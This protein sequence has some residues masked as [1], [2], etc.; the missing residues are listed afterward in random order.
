MKA[1]VKAT[2]PA[3][4]N[5]RRRSRDR[6]MS[7][8]PD[9][10]RGRSCVESYRS[11]GS[12]DS[13]RSIVQQR[14][15]APVRVRHH[16]GAPEKR[17]AALV[18]VRLAAGPLMRRSPSRRRIC[19]YPRVPQEQTFRA[20]VRSTNATFERGVELIGAAAH[21]YFAPRRARKEGVG[22]E[23]NTAEQFFPLAMQ[24]RA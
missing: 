22:A 8:T 9:S 1:N 4:L 12:F 15:G 24:S 14:S 3:L 17:Q 2:S 10:S 16:N 5:A 20:T 18:D 6:R 11:A 13:S 19:G 21:T 23:E 7:S